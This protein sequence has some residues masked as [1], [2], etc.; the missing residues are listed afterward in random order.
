MA[1]SAARDFL[2]RLKERTEN[3]DT[4][5]SMAAFLMTQLKAIRAWAHQTPD[6]LS[7]IRHPVLV[8][9]GD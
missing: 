7:R 1:A 4:P 5:V 2:R 3:R 9:N 8:A 6:D